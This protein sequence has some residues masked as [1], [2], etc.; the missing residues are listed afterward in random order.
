MNCKFDSEA[1]TAELNSKKV[2][3][4]RTMCHENN[5]QW[6]HMIEKSEL[7]QALLQHQEKASKFS[8]SGKIMPGKVAVIDDDILSKELAPGAVST[9]LLLDVFATWCGPCKTMAPFLDEAASELGDK[10]RIAKMDSDQ[11]PEWSG[12]IGVKAL[13]TLIVFDGKTGKEVERVEGAL[14]SE[15][16]VQLAKKHI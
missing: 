6:A 12:K 16:L 2:R 3:E 14:S 15:Q 4:L 7:V 13:P 5:I 11:C 1:A 8:V 10:I 9:P